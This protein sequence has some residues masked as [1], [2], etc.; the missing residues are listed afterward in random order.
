[1]L[2]RRTHEVLDAAWAAGVRYYDAARSYGRA[3][4]FLG[5]W[6]RERAIEPGSIFVGLQV[7][8]HLHR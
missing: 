4:E 6:L 5:S 2:Q 7:G 1:M 8:L 3:E